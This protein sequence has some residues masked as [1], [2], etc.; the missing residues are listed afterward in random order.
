MHFQP[1][2]ANNP[3]AKHALDTKKH[4]PVSPVYIQMED[5]R[6]AQAIVPDLLEISFIIVHNYKFT[7]TIDTYLE[8]IAT[9]T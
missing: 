6:S 5:H 9:Q 3:F 7:L 2:I 8:T 4:R 1:Q